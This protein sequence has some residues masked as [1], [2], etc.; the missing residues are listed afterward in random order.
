MFFCRNMV[1]QVLPA[2]LAGIVGLIFNGCAGY[3]LGPTS[4]ISAGAK[5]VQV[6]PFLN[7]TMEP[8]LGE[9]LTQA[10]RKSLQQ[11]GA[12]RLRT[13]GDSDVVVSGVITAFS[14]S[15]L[16]LQPN[17]LATVRDYTLYLTAQVK[18]VE[19]AS[20]K[21]LLDKPVVGRTTVRVGTDLASAERQA[22]PLLAED[23]ARKAT[24]LLVDGSW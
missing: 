8:R 20:G 2:L 7:E 1:R 13:A 9:P 15:E 12:Y 22:L 24:M 16:S 6:N 10:L 11:D 17:D 21:I 18:A 4:G 5:S 19:R 3:R 14:R 23:L